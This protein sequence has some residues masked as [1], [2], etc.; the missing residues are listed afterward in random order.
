[1]KSINLWRVFKKNMKQHNFV[2]EPR[3]YLIEYSER[4]SEIYLN[5]K[6]WLYYYKQLDRL[7]VAQNRA[8][9]Y[10]ADDNPIL[11]YFFFI[12]NLPLDFYKSLKQLNDYYLL[13]KLEKE[14]RVIGEEMIIV[15]NQISKE[16]AKYSPRLSKRR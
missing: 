2:G 7:R 12:L 6:Q 15:R 14:V 9:K 5:R 4:L 11:F 16:E 13:K 3:P 10:L 8:H 1:M